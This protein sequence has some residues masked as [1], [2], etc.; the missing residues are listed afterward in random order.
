MTNPT[1]PWA[2]WEVNLLLKLSGEGVAHKQIAPRLNQRSDDAVRRKLAK[3]RSPPAPYR[4][5]S[6]PANNL[7]RIIKERRGW[8]V[9]DCSKEWPIGFFDGEN[10]SQETLDR[11]LSVIGRRQPHRPITQTLANKGFYGR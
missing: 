1:R 5:S 7:Q 8:P 2:T 3:L 9:P 6:V 10:V 11:E 4:P